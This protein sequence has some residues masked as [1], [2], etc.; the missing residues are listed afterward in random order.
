M[1]IAIISAS[2]RDGRASHRVA[3][4][5]KEYIET[6]K[7]ADVEILDLKKYNFPVF[8]E[9]LEFQKEPKSKT[10]EFAKKIKAAAGIIIVTPEYNGGYPASLKNAIDLL[11]KEWI[12]K[13]I[14][15]ATVSSGSFG[16]MNMITSLQYSL[17][18]LHALTVPWMFPVPKV[19]DNYDEAGI[20]KDKA[21]TDKRAHKFIDELIKTI[22]AKQRMA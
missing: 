1:K 9:R 19:A 21:G 22:E 7:L 6:N 4:F 8:S 15:I 10:L 16:G 14:S 5:F 13:P 3:L 12:A 11:E 2:V 18:K 20:P 17:W